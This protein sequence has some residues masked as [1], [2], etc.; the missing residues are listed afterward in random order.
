MSNEPADVAAGATAPIDEIVEPPH[1]RPWWAPLTIAAF[2]GLVVCG[3]VAT[4]VAP[5]WVDE[6]PAGLLALSSRQRYL[7][8]T[9]AGDIGVLPYAV[10]GAV[11]LATAFVV[12]HLAARAYRDEL[13][14]LFTRYLG[15]TPAALD[16]YHKGLDKAEVFIIP[17]FV[18]S[19]IVAALTGIR[20]TPPIRLA[21]LLVIG[22][23]GRLALMWWLAQVFEDQID[24]VLKFIGRYTVPFIIIS[25]ALLLFTNV[26]NF[27]RGAGT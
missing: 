16:A 8:G 5:S 12:C 10:I 21:T 27:R 2:V 4:S 11:R 20:K 18:G 1:I 6:H 15:I 22:L 24:S 3:W 14:R 26:R 13:M 23:A 17:F 19:N 25:V 9:A 7:V